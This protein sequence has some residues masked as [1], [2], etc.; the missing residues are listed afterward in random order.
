MPIFPP[1][2]ITFPLPAN[3][4]WVSPTGSDSNVGS[5]YRPVK[6]YKRAVEIIQDLGG[7]TVLAETNCWASPTPGAGLFLRSPA[8][9]PGLGGPDWVDIPHPLKLQG[10]GA[11]DTVAQ[12]FGTSYIAPGGGASN[13]TGSCLWLA[14][15]ANGFWAS[16]IYFSGAFNATAAVALGL[17]SPLAA[18]SFSTTYDNESRVIYGGKAYLSKQNANLNNPPST[19]PDWWDQMLPDSVASSGLAWVEN[20]STL[21]FE[22][23]NVFKDGNLGPAVDHGVTFWEIWNN[24]SFQRA[25]NDDIDRL[26]SCAVR[27]V[28]PLQ[29]AQYLQKLINCNFGSGGIYVQGPSSL[30]HLENLSIENPLM[31]LVTM[32]NEPMTGAAPAWVYG[33]ELYVADAV[34]HP[35]FTLSID[36]QSTGWA[37]VERSDAASGRVI[38]VQPARHTLQ[39]RFGYGS[40]G[41]VSLMQQDSARRTFGP[42]SSDYPNVALLPSGTSNNAPDGSTTAVRPSAPYRLFDDAADSRLAIDVGDRL[43][44]GCWLKP[45]SYPLGTLML[46]QNVGSAPISFYLG[47]FLNDSERQVTLSANEYISWGPLSNDYN[48]NQWL[49]QSGWLRVISRSVGSRLT[50]QANLGNTGA[51]WRPYASVLPSSSGLDDAEAYQRALHAQSPATQNVA[52]ACVPPPTGALPFWPGVKL[53]FWDATLGT[54]KQL[55]IDNGTVRIS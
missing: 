35:E 55:D 46:I 37:M 40:V 7:G 36:N 42:A 27:Y 12:G 22:K 14:G 26:N 28:C 19:S 29:R 30:E 49:Y 32:V 41:N 51:V 23:C 13:F 11:G 5:E 16:Q 10:V 43:V 52:G 53:A 33:S 8:A 2:G 44:F 18:W 6:T 45:E 39:S 21:L 50:V 24:C 31:P 34:A 47:G 9:D 3:T 17:S 54:W 1:A 38:E 15:V 4:C 48:Y 25:R 20:T